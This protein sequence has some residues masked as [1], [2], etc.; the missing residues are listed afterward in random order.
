MPC[1]CCLDTVHDLAAG[2]LVSSLSAKNSLSGGLP[3]SYNRA[4]TESKPAQ[5]KE[6]QQPR[7]QRA[8]SNPGPKPQAGQ[9]ISCSHSHC[10]PALSGCMHVEERPLPDTRLPVISR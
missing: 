10:F 6:K 9:V 1:R 2:S 4:R 8:A 5:P 3:S 7:Q